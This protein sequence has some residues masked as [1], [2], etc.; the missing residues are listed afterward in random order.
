MKPH[1]FP[2]FPPFA[3]PLPRT[4]SAPLDAPPEPRD[5]DEFP[6]IEQFLDELPSIEDYLA[7][8][9]APV[10][11]EEGWADTGWQSFDWEGVAPLAERKAPPAPPQP[12][13]DAEWA[14][15]AESTNAREVADAL[16]RIAMRI[17][18]GE[19]P[20]DQFRGTPPADESALLDVLM[21]LSELACELPEVESLD[22]NPLVADASGV[23]AVDVRVQLRAAESARL[24]EQKE[25]RYAHCA[26]EPFPS[27]L[28]RPL[29]LR[30]GR[31]LLLRPVRPEDA[32]SRSKVGRF[33]T[34]LPNTDSSTPSTCCSVGAPMSMRARR[35]SVVCSVAVNT[36]HTTRPGCKGCSPPL[37][38]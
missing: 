35:L 38:R 21:A 20:V 30:D 27:D 7:D 29:L 2:P 32:C 24:P 14:V 19:L 23:I 15:K 16:D 1:R 11:A 6:P 33:C 12:R 3:E 31:K 22:I 28:V 4:V 26:I 9:P 37:R 25:G 36:R 34:W 10:V 13:R 18:A 8:E 5:G 17:R